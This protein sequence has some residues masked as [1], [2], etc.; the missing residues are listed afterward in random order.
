MPPRYDQ[1]IDHRVWR[2]QSST[3]IVQLAVQ[4]GNF[5][6]F[7]KLIDNHFE[8][9]RGLSRPADS[10]TSN[11]GRLQ[12]ASVLSVKFNKINGTDQRRLT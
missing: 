2:Q 1:R 10:V 12:A 11:H 7:F 8:Q 4:V 3:H 6:S 9:W 5:S